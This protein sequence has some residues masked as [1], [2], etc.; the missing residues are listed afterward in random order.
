MNLYR[1]QILNILKNQLSIAQLPPNISILDFGAGDGWFASQISKWHPESEL[2]AIDIKKREETHYIVEIVKTKDLSKISDHSVDLVYAID[3]LH[4]CEDPIDTLINLA[5]ISKNYLLI[6]DHVAF[7]SLDHLTLGILDEIGNR[8]FGI[9]SNYHYQR[10]WEWECILR[11]NNWKT[12]S[13]IW[14]APCHSGL[15]GKLTN[16]LQY[17]ALYIS[18]FA[19]DEPALQQEINTKHKP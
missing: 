15:L 9:P 7:S 2:R 12:A 5:R 14:P 8:K 4:H 16:R 3:V 18:P 10:R 19:E 17:S 6:K 1:Q 11:E 13:K